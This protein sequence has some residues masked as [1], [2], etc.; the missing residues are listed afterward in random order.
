[1]PSHAYAL[2]VKPNTAHHAGSC[3]DLEASP[4]RWMPSAA[5]DGMSS[6]VVDIAK[7]AEALAGLSAA[8]LVSLA[9]ALERAKGVRD[10]DAGDRPLITVREAAL[11]AGV[12]PKTVVNWLSAGRLTRHGVPRHPMVKRAELDE[13]L[14]PRER[15]ALVQDRH[16]RRTR[17]GITF[18]DRARQR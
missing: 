1:M 4:P 17:T 7:L 10:A 12:S 16:R 2:L 6:G 3:E 9:D 15:P 8:E 5:P 18:A 13:L 14:A 11:R